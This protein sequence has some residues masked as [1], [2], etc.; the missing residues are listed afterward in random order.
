MTANERYPDLPFLAFYLNDRKAK[1]FSSHANPQILGKEGKNTQKSKE[2]L[3]KARNSKSKERKIRVVIRIAAITLASDSATTI[4]RFRPS[5]CAMKGGG[6]FWG[7]GQEIRGV[8][9]RGAG[10]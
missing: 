10:A 5:K 9:R 1:D 3:Q 7:M 6:G 2:F 4:A 8:P